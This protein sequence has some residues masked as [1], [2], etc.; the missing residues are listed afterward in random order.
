M[1]ILNTLREQQILAA[2]KSSSHHPGD[3]ALVE[4]LSG[5]MRTSSG[6]NVTPDT[7]M[8]LSAVYAAVRRISE[9]VGMLPLNLYRRLDGDKKEKAKDLHLYNLLHSQPNAFQ[10]SMEFREYC[11]A[12]LLLRGNAYAYKQMTRGGFIESLT[13]LPPDNM[14]PFWVH[15]RRGQIAYSYTDPDSGGQEIFLPGEIFHL[16]GLSVSGGLSGLNPI[17]YH[18]ETIGLGLAAQEYGAKFYANAATPSGILEH[19]NHFKDGDKRKEFRRSF[20]E[21]VTGS[22]R[23]APVVLEDN[24]KFTQLGI[25][26]K[27]AQYIETTKQTVTEVARMFL[28]SPHMIGDLDRATFSNITQLSLEHVI[29]TLMP[30][31]VRWEQSTARDLFITREEKE[32][33]FIKFNAN[34]LLR[35][36]IKT[37]FEAYRMGILDGL[38]TRNE[39]R[40]LEDLNPG[41]EELDEYLQPSNM[42]EAG[43]PG[44]S[45]AEPANNREQQ[46]TEAAATRIVYKEYK[47]VRKLFEKNTTPA[48]RKTAFAGFYQEH[49]KFVADVLG[50]AARDAADYCGRSIDRWHDYIEEYGDISGRFENVQYHQLLITAA[51]AAK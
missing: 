10:T 37:R 3:P 18:R 7:A 27:D 11:M 42:A 43:E 1:G 45:A 50:V 14:R 40:L 32:T 22:D 30:W 4:M 17:E 16:R 8:R 19:P 9:G 25:N 15:R 41:P 51:L 34:G 23:H 44:S 2:T 24:I 39:V 35:G 26:Q 46:L 49:E 48:A 33:L 31:F 13:P 6:Q 12:G 38:M 28:M 29:Y 5:G 21:Q 47:A 36:D 20:I